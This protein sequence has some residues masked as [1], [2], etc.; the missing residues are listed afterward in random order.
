[1]KAFLISLSI[2]VAGN[3]AHAEI[4][5]GNT[6]SPPYEIGGMSGLGLYGDQAAWSFLGNVATLIEPEGWIE[7]ID[8]RVW[9]E[10]Q[11]GPAFFSVQGND[12]TAFQY[13]THVRW[14]F[15]R[16]GTWTVY[17]LGG[18][19]GFINA[20]G[21]SFSFHPRFGIGALFQTKLPLVFRFEL[22]HEFSGLGVAFNF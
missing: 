9:A 6:Q 12:K 2:F 5:K 19:A 1:M 4:W 18:V 14:D 15:T 8:D 13:S 16:D 17:G 20:P 7:D 11:G 22:S 21:D 10:F 3:L